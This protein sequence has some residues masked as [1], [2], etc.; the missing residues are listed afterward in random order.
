MKV[1]NLAQFTNA[2]R[3][4]AGE[5]GWGTVLDWDDENVKIAFILDTKGWP[6][7][8][9]SKEFVEVYPDESR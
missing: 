3:P 5:L 6:Y 1:G 8:W 7:R 4:I 2:G 9:I